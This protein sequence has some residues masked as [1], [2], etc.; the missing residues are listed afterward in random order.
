MTL[1]ATA[2]DG[3]RIAY[4]SVGEGAPVLLIH[5]FAASRVQNWRAPGWYETLNGA[6]Y[7][8][9]AMDCRGHGESGKPHEPA[10]YD[11]EIMMDDAVAVMREAQIGPAFVM[12]Y[13]MGGYISIYLLLR[14][15]ELVRKLAFGGVGATY[16]AGQFGS[17]EAIADALL[18][19]DKTKI[20]NPIARRFREFA[21][22][23]GK[24]V[25]A[26]AA[27]MRG[28]RKP[29]SASELSHSTRPVLVVCGEND[30]L[31]GPPGPTRR[32]IRRWTRGDGAAPRSHDDGWRQ[33]LQAGCAAILRGIGRTVLRS[34]KL[35]RPALCGPP[36]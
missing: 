3:T 17:R 4:E 26:L 15:P 8:V 5:G 30:D 35:S 7:R 23:G 1:F 6:G 21:E 12:G 16:L 32:R 14:H 19:P 36:R 20:L 2:S 10:A 18:A 27:C 22:Q 9:V 28:D 31:T 24:D 13:S 11:H 29:L 34:T 25:E 33:D